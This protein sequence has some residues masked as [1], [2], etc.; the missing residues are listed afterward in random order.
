M[1]H[2]HMRLCES[3]RMHARRLHVHVLVRVQVDV[4]LSVRTCIRAY[5]HVRAFVHVRV[6]ECVLISND[7]FSQKSRAHALSFFHRVSTFDEAD[8]LSQQM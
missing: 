4:R 7:K 2:K 3:A 5:V 6:C 1:L 8:Y